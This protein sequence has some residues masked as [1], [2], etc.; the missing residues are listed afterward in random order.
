MTIDQQTVK[1][2]Q[3]YLTSSDFSEFAHLEHN[4]RELSSSTV[5]NLE[6][7]LKLANFKKLDWDAL[8]GKLL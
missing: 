8:E 6:S 5:K 2:S 1:Q 3:F 7:Q 4:L